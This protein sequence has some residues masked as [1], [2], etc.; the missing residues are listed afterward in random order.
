MMTPQQRLERMRK[1]FDKNRSIQSEDYVYFTTP[2][3]S[4][5]RAS[6]HQSKVVRKSVGLSAPKSPKQS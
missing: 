6:T 1:S 4:T 2:D 3:P 5:P